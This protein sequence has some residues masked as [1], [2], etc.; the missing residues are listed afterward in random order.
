MMPAHYPTAKRGE[1]RLV[2]PWYLIFHF[3]ESR[4]G[5]KK[6]NYSSDKKEGTYRSGRAEEGQLGDPGSELLLEWSARVAGG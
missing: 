5:K 1:K 2:D 6:I 4:R 3:D